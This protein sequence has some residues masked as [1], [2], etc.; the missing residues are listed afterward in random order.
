MHGRTVQLLSV[1]ETAAQTAMH[2][3]SVSDDGHSVL[4]NTPSQ[5]SV[6]H[7]LTQ[8]TMTTK[9]VLTKTVGARTEVERKEIAR[10]LGHL[11]VVQEARLAR[12]KMRPGSRPQSA[13][14]GSAPRAA[15]YTPV[16]VSPT[17]VQAALVLRGETPLAAAALEVQP[18]ISRPGTAQGLRTV[19]HGSGAATA[20][21][22]V[23]ETMLQQCS[24]PLRPAT[25]F[26]QT[27]PVR[28]QTPG[29][30]AAPRR[31]PT[32]GRNVAKKPELPMSS[33]IGA[34]PPQAPE[35]PVDAEAEERA[36][37]LEQQLRK[38][39]QRQLQKLAQV[40]IDAEDVKSMSAGEIL[41][42]LYSRGSGS[43]YWQMTRE[44]QKTVNIRPITPNC[45]GKVLTPRAQADVKRARDMPVHHVHECLDKWEIDTLADVCRS[46][47][48]FDEASQ[49][50]TSEYTMKYSQRNYGRPYDRKKWVRPPTG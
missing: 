48:H 29:T 13:G 32:P 3:E 20:P 33:L 6:F 44:V 1:I 18:L 30:V 46:I 9:D 47:R 38:A 2:K 41:H 31:P 19:A 45:L 37:E 27:V 49:S 17:A 10:I 14:V 16:R 8:A 40:G 15:C 25:P 12:T 42:I 24:I 26:A 22:T 39:N 36:K 50:L 43:S 7:D 4:G 21:S 35:A 23:L 11:P 5:L 34:A 28:P